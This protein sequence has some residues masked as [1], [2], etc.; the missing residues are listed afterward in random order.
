M[1]LHL[2]RHALVIFA[3][4]VAANDAYDWSS[5][6]SFG[7]TTPAVEWVMA[8]Q[9]RSTV[10]SRLLPH[11]AYPLPNNCNFEIMRRSPARPASATLRAPYSYLSDTAVDLAVLLQ[12]RAV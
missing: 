12:S 3:I 4:A 7:V 8:R 2:L 1:S 5:G 6:A 11:E 10:A 9:V